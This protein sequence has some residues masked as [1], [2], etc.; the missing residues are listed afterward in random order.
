[1]KTN[2]AYEKRLKRFNFPSGFAMLL[3][4]LLLPAMAA[5][6]V[7]SVQVNSSDAVLINRRVVAV[8][9]TTAQAAGNLNVVVVG[10]NDTSSSVVSVTDSN[11]NTY[12]LAATTES[13]P[14]PS[15]SGLQQGVSQAIYYAKK[16]N[17]GANTVTVIFNQTTAVQSVRIVEYTGL[18]TLNPLDTS[19]GNNGTALVADSGSVTT[20]SAND[21]L[22]G[23]G[24][25]TTG[26]TGSGAG[27]S[28]V[29]LNGLG[30]IVEDQVVT[31]A[32]SHNATATLTTGVWVMQMVAFRAAGQVAPTFAAP[33]ISSLS[34]TSGP[35]AGETA[36]TLTGTNFE[37]G[38]AVL[39]SNSGGFTAPGVNC[40]VA[41]S[42]T[43]NCLTPSFPVG[44]ASITVTNVDGQASSPSAFTFTASTPFATA[45][46]PSI[47]PD[48]GSTNGATVVT[49]SGSDF[50][51]GAAVTVGGLPADRIAVIN[52]NTILV[53]LPAGKA[54]LAPVVVTNPSGT[55]GTLPS[56][57][58]YAAGTTGI[59][60]VQQNSAQSASP[61]T[62]AV[63]NYTL[64]QTLGNLNVVIVGWADATTT[65]TSVVDS[66][67]N[68]YTL[69][70]PVTIGNGL[71][72]AIYFAK[73]ILAS[74]SNAV[75][76]TF[77][78]VAQSDVRILEY[79]GLDPAN[80]LD[81]TNGATGSGTLLDSGAVIPTVSGDLVVG[82]SMAGGT[83]ITVSPTFTTVAK[84]P[85][86][87][88]VEHLVGPS[89]GSLHATAI[90]NSSTNWVMQAVAFRQ[91]V[92]V[93]DFTISVTPPNT[94]TVAAGSP[95]TYTISVA[96]VLGFNSAVTLTCSG[97]PLGTSCAFNPPTVTPG[98]TAVTSVLT[99]TTAAATP[100]A[101]ST[102]TVTGTFSSLSHNT[103][104]SLTV[105]A[106]FAIAA[107]ALSPA[108]VLAGTPSTST[109]T[110][111]PTS[112]FT[113][114]VT[115]SCGSIMPTGTNDPT[116]SFVPL[117]VTGGS[118]TSV[119]TVNTV[120]TTSPVVYT[121]TITGTSG[122]LSHFASDTLIVTAPAAD[123][124]IAA[125]ALAPATVAAGA[126][127]T[128]TI[129]IAPAAGTSFNSA[130]ALTCSVAPAATRGPTCAFN[131][132]SVTNGS[133]TSVLT[134]S[135]TAATTAS[136]A[137]HSSG[138]FYAMLLPIGGLTCLAT[139]LTS[140]KK[141]LWSF[142]LGCLLFSTL[143]ILPA[144][145]G[146][147]ST[148]GGGHPGTPA[149]T[150]TVTVTGTSGSR[151]HPTTV[152]LIVQ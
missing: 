146:S 69:A 2:F 41:S 101:T 98:A 9:F 17:A 60:F 132:V 95:A 51:A 107:T 15:P 33:T 80:P 123:F 126:S 97:L 45:A 67:G 48:T 44:L 147:G 150:Y 118:G 37:S 3:S 63:V 72:Q 68:T 131:P 14:V 120:A 99:I 57:Y 31:T 112:G 140:R 71:S 139:G 21:L 20:N 145:G 36:V 13:T 61:A 54:G 133:G 134:V 127:S 103:T 114:T 76:V 5:G 81:D 28:T 105:I 88:S 30:D 128:S 75:T 35:E 29:L 1:M 100:A 11:G 55:V 66:A 42:T 18:D 19:V 43:I 122:S 138:L 119:L 32:A 152:S 144:C 25:I 82:A 130:V 38:A 40:G 62:T 79:S 26:F 87:I 50:A 116:C 104:V 49:I 64:A 141:K 108:S 65:V 94:A 46:S 39:F 124:T 77:S 24:T 83:V 22:F 78:A 93:P 6:Q 4:W 102:V 115:L 56:G 8:P 110:I 89:A 129:T 34:A 136:L 27:F 23:A 58:T 16:I 59:N 143:I 96:P 92:A 52:V 10:W 149:G 74:G 142:L 135:T 125:T 73:S 109:V 47:T 86:G 113:G 12:A 53:S 117:S 137:P 85:G 106:D 111:T 91:A 151:T 70:F 7:S 148:G 121:L 90:Q 84:T